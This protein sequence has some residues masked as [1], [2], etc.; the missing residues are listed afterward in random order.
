MKRTMQKETEKSEGKSLTLFFI[1]VGPKHTGMLTSAYATCMLHLCRQERQ[2][3]Q[4][5]QLVP[6]GLG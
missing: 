3:I 4:D 1:G 6:V 5:Y 2:S